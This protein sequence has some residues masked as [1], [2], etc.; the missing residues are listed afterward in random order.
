MIP[1]EYYSSQDN[2]GNYQF[3]TL[4]DF[5]D[6]FMIETTDEDSYLSNVPRSK[7]VTQAV[8]GIR[9]L[10]REIKKTVKAVEMSVGPEMYL[11][12]PQDYVDWVRVSVIDQ[13]GHLQPLNINV[14]INRAIGY[15]QD[16]NGEILFDE[17]GYILQ[18]DANNYLGKPYAKYQFTSN[19]NGGCFEL[20]T[21][22]LSIY[23]E[24]FI[25]EE[26]GTIAFSSD[27]E[28]KE[29]VLEYISDGLEARDIDEKAITINK[30]LIEALSD[31]VY[32]E[33]ISKRRSVPANEK[34]RA[35]SRYKSTLHKTKIDAA[36]FDI[37][38]ISRILN[39][40]GRQG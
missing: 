20:D 25:D 8:A 28:D 6:E 13:Q 17:Q 4:K 10:N 33:C 32:S 29:I 2:W 27:L 3:R 40:G 5:V 26:R 12:L 34:Q 39:L 7:I 14:R 16:D 19:L 11:I 36:N 35:R 37:N 23:G 9:V 38:Q 18:A 24:F 30:Q 15:L 1:E 21:S 31:W 22:K